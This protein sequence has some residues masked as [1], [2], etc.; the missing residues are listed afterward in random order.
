MAALRCANHLAPI[1]TAFVV[2]GLNLEK[3]HIGQELSDPAYQD[4]ENCGEIT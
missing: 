2:V 1:A 3:I 4:T